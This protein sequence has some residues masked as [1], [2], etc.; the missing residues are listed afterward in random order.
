MIVF[1]ISTCLIFG[2]IASYYEFH[3]L[4]IIFGYAILGVIVA[5]LKKLRI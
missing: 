3:F 5:S 4:G 1:S 2:F